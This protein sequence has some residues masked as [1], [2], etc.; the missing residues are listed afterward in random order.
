[1]QDEYEQQLKEERL[2][3]MLQNEVQESENKWIIYDD[4]LTE[5]K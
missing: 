4:E 2:G 1:M 5:V 3:I